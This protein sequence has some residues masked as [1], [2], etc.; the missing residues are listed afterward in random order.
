MV[1]LRRS[2][3]DK[4]KLTDV[5]IE[6]VEEFG[7]ET[8]CYLYY[9]QDFNTLALAM[10]RHW[11]FDDKIFVQFLN[12]IRESEKIK[13]SIDVPLLCSTVFLDEFDVIVVQNNVVSDN[14]DLDDFEY[15]PLAIEA[16]QREP[17]TNKKKK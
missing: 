13:P 16:F 11:D 9:T 6:F 1:K 14:A 4:T 5:E 3:I 12:R 8:C 2:E 15:V 17:R 7:E 10:S